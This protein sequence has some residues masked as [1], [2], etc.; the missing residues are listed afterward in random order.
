[1][2]KISTFKFY[3]RISIL[4][5]LLFWVG[6]GITVSST[7]PWTSSSPC[8]RSPPRCSLCWPSP[9]TGGEPSCPRYI[10]GQKPDLQVEVDRTKL[11]NPIA[12]FQHLLSFYFVKY[13]W[14]TLHN[15]SFLLK[16]VLG[17]LYQLQNW[18]KMVLETLFRFSFFPF[19]GWNFQSLSIWLAV[20]FV[21]FVSYLNF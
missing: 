2:L 8:A 10:P 17:I 18:K 1:M 14:G 12:M 11:Y 16:H 4:I 15:S 7:A 13:V 3:F 6:T 19:R 9:W 20:V 21:K 5:P